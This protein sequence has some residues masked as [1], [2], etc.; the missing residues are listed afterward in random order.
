MELFAPQFLN[1]SKPIL[2]PSPHQGYEGFIANVSKSI[3]SLDL[4]RHARY[5]GW[6]TTISSGGEGIPPPHFR[7]FLTDVVANILECVDRCVGLLQEYRE[8]VVTGTAWLVCGWGVYMVWRVCKGWNTGVDA[9]ELTSRDVSYIDMSGNHV[10]G[11][12]VNDDLDPHSLVFPVRGQRSRRGSRLGRSVSRGRDLHR[13]LGSVSIHSL[14]SCEDNEDLARCVGVPLASPPQTSPL[15]TRVSSSADGKG[16]KLRSVPGVHRGLV[17][18]LHRLDQA[19]LRLQLSE[20]E[21]DSLREEVT[22]Y[23]TQLT[24]LH[25]EVKGDREKMRMMELENAELRRWKRSPQSHRSPLY[26]S[27]QSHRS[28]QSQHARCEEVDRI[29]R[30]LKEKAA[31]SDRIFDD[32]HQSPVRRHRHAGPTRVRS[33]DDTTR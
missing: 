21:L 6:T 27:P 24:Y 28:P 25:R 15:P 4:P 19:K 2:N 14:L 16:I 26:R 3:N 20:C 8:E 11:T 5:E 10:S 23:S 12:H 30:V 33:V 32:F 1:V 7:H 17:E 13:R 31:S 22:S 18:V 29:H 9:A